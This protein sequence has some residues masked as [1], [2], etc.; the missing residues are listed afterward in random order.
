MS[1]GKKDGTG[2]G[3]A[4]AKKVVEAHNGSINVNSQIGEGADFVISLPIVSAF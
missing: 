2:L 1:E 4:I 3:L